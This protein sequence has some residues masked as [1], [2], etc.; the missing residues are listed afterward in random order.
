[1]MYASLPGGSRAVCG[2][3]LPRHSSTPPEGY[4]WGVFL[5]VFGYLCLVVFLDRAN[6]YVLASVNTYHMLIGLQTD[7]TRPTCTPPEGYR[8][9]VFLD[10][11]SDVFWEVILDKFGCILWSME[12]SFMARYFQYGLYLKY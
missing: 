2:V 10:R 3:G 7:S 11:F 9:A 6:Y 5:D 8:W 4:K 1:M 12:L